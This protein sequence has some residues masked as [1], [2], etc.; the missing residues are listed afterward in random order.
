MDFKRTINRLDT[1]KS[2]SVKTNEELLSYLSQITTSEDS[3]TNKLVE[4]IPPDY[5]G[6]AF[7][8]EKLILRYRS[9]EVSDLIPVHLL[10]EEKQKAQT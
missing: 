7:K 2:L 1:E 9:R 5:T 6:P 3:I 10:T 4:T 8:V